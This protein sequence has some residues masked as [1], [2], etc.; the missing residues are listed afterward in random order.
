M[1]AVTQSQVDHLITELVPHV[2]TEAH[3]EELGLK[4]YEW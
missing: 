2:D 4:V 1:T 3:Q